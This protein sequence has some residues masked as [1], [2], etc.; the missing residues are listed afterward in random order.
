MKKQSLA[1]L[2]LSSSLLLASCANP[3]NTPSSSQEETTSETKVSFTLNSTNF[4][5]GVGQSFQLVAF[6]SGVS[7]SSSDASVA[8]VDSNGL[9]SAIALGSAIITAEKEGA[10]VLAK[11]T[12]TDEAIS[13][14]SVSFSSASL[15]LY[16]GES[17]SLSPSVKFGSLVVEGASIEYGSSDAEVASYVDGKVSALAKGS[18]SIYAKVTYNGYSASAYASVEVLPLTPSISPNFKERSVVAGEEGL[19]LDFSLLVA[20]EEVEL[21][22]SFLYS[23]SDETIAEIVEGKLVGKKRGQ[24]DLTV[25]ILYEGETIT[26]TI[27]FEVKETI[28][29]SFFSEGSLLEE[30][31]I[32][33]GESL[34]LDIAAPTLEGYVFKSFLDHEGKAYEKGRTFDYD[35]SFNASWCAESGNIDGAKGE[36]VRSFGAA[37]AS[38]FSC[39]MSLIQGNNFINYEEGSAYDAGMTE[40]CC[41]LN[42]QQEGVNDYDL[43]FPSFDFLSSGRVDFYFGDNYGGDSITIGEKTYSSIPTRLEVSVIPAGEKASLYLGGSYFTDLS[44]DVSSG[45]EGLSLTFTRLDGHLYQQFY[46]GAFTKYTYDYMKAIDNLIASLPEDPSSLSAEE[47]GEKMRAYAE[48]IDYLT[49]YEASTYVENVKIAA[50]RNALKGETVQL[51]TLPDTYNWDTIRAMGINTDGKGFGGSA[52]EGILVIN[53]QD[54]GKSDSITQFVEFP[55]INYSLYTSVSFKMKHGYDGASLKI[56]EETLTSSIGTELG[57]VK[58]ATSEGETTISYNGTTLTLSDEVAHGKEGLRFDITRDRDL[59]MAYDW[60]GFTPFVGEF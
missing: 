13:T 51:F 60:F 7:Y 6:T 3:G 28:E 30:Y 31:Q 57:E 47:A 50:L 38:E 53:F 59:S 33:N 55:K 12:V 52:E 54:G 56:G 19:A 5:L 4:S 32:L 17:I 18:A 26:S 42:F 44:E 2:I 27:A 34:N 22:S 24:V 23:L 21:T 45:K 37:K 16:E 10:K 9:V 46:I 48:M 36:F 43:T 49:P 58:I 8:Q 41:K 15:A 35:T 1:L 39:S 29:I 11:V 14:L 40:G 25:S 20:D